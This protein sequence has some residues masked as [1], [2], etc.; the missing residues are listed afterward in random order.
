MA[1]HGNVRDEGGAE[2]RAGLTSQAQTV[3]SLHVPEDTNPASEG[4]GTLRKDLRA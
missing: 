3:D 4:Q 2:T 1:N